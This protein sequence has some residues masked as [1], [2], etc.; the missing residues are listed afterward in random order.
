MSVSAFCV[1]HAAWD[2]SMHVDAY[3]AENA[4]AET[5]LLLESGGGPAANAAWLLARWGVRTA[6]AA[7]VGQDLYGAKAV[8]ELAEAGVDC[9][10]VEQRTGHATPLSFII[11]NRVNGSRTIINRKQ[12]AP[13][14][15]LDSRNLAGIGP[16]LLLFDGHELDAAQAALEAF[17]TAITLLDAGSMRAGTVAL[18]AKVRYLVCSE[19]FA[20]QATGQAEVAGDWA[21]CLRQLRE[22]YGN[23]VVVTL[24]TRGVAFDDGQQRGHVPALPVTTCDT[25][26]AGD[27]FHGAFAFAL[28]QGLGLRQA[29]QLANT[30]AGLSVQVPGGRWSAPKLSDVLERLPHE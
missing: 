9:G 12:P 24:G 17:P 28:L 20:A 5:D 26:A 14:M 19:R 25:T 29:L 13:T 18:A 15:R 30:A 6:L 23:V 27:I 3:P 22:R 4:K 16:K 2:L 10:F 11:V 21:A 8:Q 1:G 7:V